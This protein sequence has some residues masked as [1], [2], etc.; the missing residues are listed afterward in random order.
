MDLAENLRSIRD[1]IR[2]AC[3]RAGR[4]PE[5]VRLIAA[6]KT[7]APDVLQGLS[8]FGCADFGENRIQEALPKI[9]ALTGLPLTWHFI[10]R[11][12]RNKAKFVPGRFTWVHSVD[13]VELAEELDR[14]A[15]SAGA[16][17]RCLVEVNLSGE[18]QKE[19]ISPSGLD[20]LLQKAPFLTHLSFE[21]L[22]TVPPLSADPM[23]LKRLFSDTRELAS[24]RGLKEL[25]MGM[26]GDFEAAIEEGATMIRIG[27]A[28][29][30]KRPPVPRGTI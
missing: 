9:E 1:R 3:D 24:R 27:A 23:D 21:G 7:V 25:S 15:A 13:S 11:L 5:T 22:M 29:F 20:P 2:R 30:G 28:L 4:D 17:I 26:S 12:Q 18:P 6:S 10:G 19:G 8:A 14:R 16:R